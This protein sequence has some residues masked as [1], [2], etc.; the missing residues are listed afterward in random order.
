MFQLG[1]ARARFWQSERVAGLGALARLP[2]RPVGDGSDGTGWATRR[3]ASKDRSDV[4]VAVYGG[5]KRL[6]RRSRWRRSPPW[7]RSTNMGCCS[8]RRSR[9]R[10]RW[11][12]RSSS[13]FLFL[14]LG[15]GMCRGSSVVVRRETVKQRHGLGYIQDTSSAQCSRQA[16]AESAAS[17]PRCVVAWVRL[18]GFRLGPWAADLMVPV[19]T[20][21]S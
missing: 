13:K 20:A 14:P 3:V 11:K 21:S 18:R 6:A 8:R 17:R 12:L 1:W 16:N 19:L 15:S 9:R 2:A 10:R 4:S 7:R 5:A